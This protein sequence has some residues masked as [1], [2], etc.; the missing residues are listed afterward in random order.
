MSTDLTE[1]E[2][3]KHR[4]ALD[5]EYL[6]LVER[7]V[8]LEPY[9]PQWNQLR[10]TRDIIRDEQLRLLTD[11]SHSLTIYKRSSRGISGLF[12]RLLGPTPSDM[13]HMSIDDEAEATM[14]E[15]PSYRIPALLSIIGAIAVVMGIALIAP[16]LFVSPLSLLIGLS[17]GSA[18]TVTSMAH[19]SV[20]IVVSAIVVGAAIGT[21][22]RSRKKAGRYNR[23]IALY[24][25]M[26][27]RSGAENWTIWQR[28]ISCLMFGAVNLL[29]LIFPLPGVIIIGVLGAL[30][31]MVYL[32]EYSRSHDSTRA[33][34]ASTKFSAAYNAYAMAALTVLVI[35]AMFGPIFFVL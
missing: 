22:L 15:L 27:Y 30:A 26:R 32:R 35:F 6:N 20:V 10:K 9:S 5:Y 29:V 4:N 8:Y 3:I 2:Y 31:M 16:A 21:F 14:D 19:S 25:E 34:L 18:I 11:Y 23:E 7:M 12:N 1:T 28:F 17:T 33:T 24:S 13:T